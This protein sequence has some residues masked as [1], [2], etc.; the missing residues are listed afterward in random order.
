[1]D[2]NVGMSGGLGGVPR[3]NMNYPDGVCPY[4]F[5]SFVTVSNSS[6]YLASKRISPTSPHISISRVSGIFVGLRISRLVRLPL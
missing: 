6:T 4:G 1:M 5:I 3:M 2:L